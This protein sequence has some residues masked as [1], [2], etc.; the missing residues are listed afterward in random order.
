LESEIE[1]FDKS[2]GAE[3]G[4][5]A[6][7]SGADAEAA[8]AEPAAAGDM[9]LRPWSFAI[10]AASASETGAAAGWAGVGFMRF[11]YMSSTMGTSSSRRGTD[12]SKSVG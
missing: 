6:P 8:G 12:I 7:I 5:E 3:A 11:S 2:G 4:A 1:R 10:N 9:P